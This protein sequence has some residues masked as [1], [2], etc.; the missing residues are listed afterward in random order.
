MKKGLQ[1]KE[2]GF[3]KGYRT[4]ELT[5]G[6]NPGKTPPELITWHQT[7]VT[8]QRIEVWERAQNRF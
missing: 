3:G 2:N 1:N 5:R 8:E 4:S 6:G 7:K